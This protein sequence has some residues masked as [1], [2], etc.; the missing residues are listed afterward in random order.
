MGEQPTATGNPRDDVCVSC[1]VGAHQACARTMRRDGP[2]SKGRDVECACAFTAHTL[3][4]ADPTMTTSV[5]EVAVDRRFERPL[6][7]LAGYCSGARPGFLKHL[8]VDKRG[9]PVP[10][11]SDWTGSKDP[12]LHGR[13]GFAQA[14]LWAVGCPWP[15]VTVL[16]PRGKPGTGAPML[17]VLHPS[18]QRTCMLDR[19][20]QVCGKRVNA[21]EKAYL[22]GGAALVA[23][24]F[25]EPPMHLRCAVFSLF[26]CPGINRADMVVAEA[27]GYELRPLSTRVDLQAGTETE[28]RGWLRPTE[29]YLTF[30]LAVPA[31]DGHVHLNAPAFRDAHAHLLGNP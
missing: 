20:C 6:S 25:R 26:A 17:A 18:R 1:A 7:T 8:P 27:Y 31:A 23:E 10:W 19:K 14:D 3:V 9:F 22:A 30:L 15:T 21:T 2:R 4:Q 29:G 11:V 5:Q 28:I 16:E 12:D 13:P 24:G